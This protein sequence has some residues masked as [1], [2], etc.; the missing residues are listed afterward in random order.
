MTMAVIAEAYLAHL[1]ADGRS[2]S[3]CATMKRT[4]ALLVAYLGANR[5]VGEVAIQDL[6][7]SRR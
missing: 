5:E 4:F 6:D 2:P 1:Q 7:V 3:T